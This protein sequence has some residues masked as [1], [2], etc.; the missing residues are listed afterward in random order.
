MRILP[1]F[2]GLLMTTLGLHAQSPMPDAGKILEGARL[3]ASLTK[4]EKGL[5]GSIRSN[6]NKIPLTLF[7]RGN[8]I[9]FQYTDL[10]GTNRIFHMRLGDAAYDLFEIRDGK[11]MNFP[12]DRLVQPIANS[13]LTYEDLALRFFYWPNPTLEGNESVAGED[14]FKIRINK[15]RSSAGRYEVVYVWVSIK[16]GAFMRVRG[17]DANGGLLKEFQVQDV[18]Q[19]ANGVWTLRKMQVSSHDPATGRRQSI[20][21]VTFDSPNVRSGPRSLR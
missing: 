21:D 2:C 13:D 4:L 7:L 10:D 9:Q 19:V 8:D 3:S 5:E 18:M 17:H 12:A 14:C 20:T 6:G 16:H 15:P 1:A 11:T